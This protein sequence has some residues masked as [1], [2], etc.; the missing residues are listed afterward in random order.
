MPYRDES[1]LIED[2]PANTGTPLGFVPP[3]GPFDGVSE[4]STVSGTLGSYYDELNDTYWDVDWVSIELS[5]AIAYTITITSTGPDFLWD[6]YDSEGN[7]IYVEGNS[8]ALHSRYNWSTNVAEL[9]FS[10]IKDTGTQKYFIEIGNVEDEYFEDDYTITVNQRD[11]SGNDTIS[12]GSGDD[13]LYGGPGDDFLSAGSGND[14]TNYLYGGSGNDILDGGDGFSS[15]YGGSGDDI[16]DSG[17]NA[18]LNGGTGDDEL[19]GGPG[20]DILEGGP[21][22]DRLTGGAPNFVEIPNKSA[23]EIS[24][25]DSTM[26][27]TVRLHTLQARGGDAEG[28]IFAGLVTYTY[29]NDEGIKIELSFSDIEHIRGSDYADILAG[30][31]RNNYIIGGDGDDTIYGGPGRS[32]YVGYG[33]LDNDDILEGGGGNDRLFGGGGND[34]LYG[35]DGDNELRG[36][37]GDD[38]LIGGDGDDELIG[39]DGDDE[40]IGGDGDDELW[41]GDGND[42]AVNFRAG[43]VGGPGDDYLNGG[44]GQD[45]LE[46]GPGADI[47]IGGGLDVGNPFAADTASYSGSTEGVTVRLHSRQALGG[48]AN[49]DTFAGSDIYTY[50][51]RDGD[52]IEVSFPDIVDLDGSGH[53]DILAGDF[54]NNLIRGG[55]GDDKIYGGA[56]PADYAGGLVVHNSYGWE[57]YHFNSDSLYGGDGNDM[58][59]GGTGNDHLEGGDGDDELRGGDGNDRLGGGDGDDMLVG[60]AGDDVFQFNLSAGNDTILDYGNGEDTI[61]IRD[62]GGK[63]Q[64]VTDLALQQQGDNL[65]IDLTPHGEGTITVLDYEHDEATGVSL[66]IGDYGVTIIL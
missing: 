65:L 57:E 60:G 11:I 54:R 62:S 50:T 16:L 7:D 63:I 28:D 31:Q 9:F 53:A 44:L 14:S 24:Y 20:L 61:Y 15:L 42:R 26:G 39:G 36:G 33:E 66:D 2:A 34:V 25:A 47:L 13:Y 1:D 29:T 38:E 52:K 23:D 43:L 5:E 18:Y 22:A 21:G 6:L 35:G 32:L 40:L 51:N 41:G 46:G 30:D 58:I 8:I 64:S 17:N 10:P 37:D 45:T 59:F 3:N 12:G 19:N 55:D 27:V 49:G 4:A 48:D 56:G